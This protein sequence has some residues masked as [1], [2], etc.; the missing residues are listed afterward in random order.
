MNDKFK[1]EKLLRPEEASR[2]LNITQ[3]SLINWSNQGK[4]ECIRT[5][6][7]HR[8]FLMSSLVPF[9]SEEID[10]KNEQRKR[11]I[12]YC[13]VSTSSQKE[14]LERQIKFF[15]IKYP[16]YEIIKD[17]G[18]GINFKRKGF[19]TILD[20][21]IKGN[22]KEVVVTHKDR[23]CR[24]GFELIEGIIQEY[25]QGQILV[26]NKKE[27]SPHEE[28]VNDLI[29]IITVFSSRLYGLRSS[30]IKNQIRETATKKGKEKSGEK[31][32]EEYYGG[33]ELENTEI[34]IISI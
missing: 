6:G 32:G 29:S 11:K 13:R 2:L 20:D 17:I 10:R 5:K 24:F 21:A 31:S 25:S 26:L 28:L 14:D 4:I 8:R 12:C 9:A 15:R 7:K 19:K 27:T 30:K 3:Q 18:S 1:K 34:S 23:L 33:R 22:I 16:E